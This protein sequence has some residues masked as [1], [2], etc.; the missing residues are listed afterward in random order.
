MCQ[1]LVKQPCNC[2]IQFSNCEPQPTTANGAPPKRWTLKP[3]SQ[4]YPKWTSWGDPFRVRGFCRL[5]LERRSGF[6]VSGAISETFPR[7]VA[8]VLE[9]SYP[10][11]VLPEASF[12]IHLEFQGS[13]LGLREPGTELQ[14]LSTRLGVPATGVTRQ[15]SNPGQGWE[16]GAGFRTIPK[17]SDP[18][19]ETSNPGPAISNPGSLTTSTLVLQ[20]RTLAP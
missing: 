6:H 8:G 5:G 1:I 20:Y 14:R 7:S 10:S 16:I 4:I 19:H 18:S 2:V 9:S 11:I 17:A 3:K 13:G 15:T 12:G